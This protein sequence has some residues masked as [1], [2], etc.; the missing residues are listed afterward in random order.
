MLIQRSLEVQLL[1][2]G[3]KEMSK[4]LNYPLKQK[5]KRIFSCSLICL[6]SVSA[7]WRRQRSL[8]GQTAWRRCG[9]RWRVRERARSAW[10]PTTAE[11]ASPAKKPVG[12][13]RSTGTERR[14]GSRCCKTL[15]VSLSLQAAASANPCAAMA[16][17]TATT[18]LTKTTARASTGGRTNAPP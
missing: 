8:G 1:F 7:T 16:S 18:P 11:T 3:F 6:S 14:P 9:I 13:T 12:F 4:M 17:Q 10:S 5:Q 15:R 2:C